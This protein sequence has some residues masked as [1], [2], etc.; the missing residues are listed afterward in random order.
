MNELKKEI[1][2]QYP[3]ELKRHVFKRNS[4]LVIAD[5]ITAQNYYIESGVLIML[6][7]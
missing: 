6:Y 1:L 7:V 2:E 3:K 4:V 5:T